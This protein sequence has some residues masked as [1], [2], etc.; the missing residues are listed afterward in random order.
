[1]GSLK[2][3]VLEGKTGFVFRP[4]DPVDLAK[5]I[6]KYFESELFAHLKTRRQE[7]CSYATERNSWSVV[8]QTTMEVYG[9][10]LQA[11]CRTLNVES[12]ECLCWLKPPAQNVPQ[13]V[14]F[15]IFPLGTLK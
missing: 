4:E 3:E 7:I 8:A 2:D 13:A 14:L 15:N 6:R 1:M 11:S 9:G 5:A 10:M 12:I